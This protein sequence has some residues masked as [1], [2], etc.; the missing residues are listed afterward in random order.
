MYGVYPFGSAPFGAAPA[1][2]APTAPTAERAL[3]LSSR[4]FNNATIVGSTE[5]ASLPASYLQDVQPAKVWRLTSKIGQYLA[6]TLAR[7][8]ACDTV[9]F[10]AANFTSA[11]VC[12]VIAAN[13]S[14]SLPASPDFNSG[15]K[16]VWP[17]T[18]KSLDDDIASFVCLVRFANTDAYQH[19]RIEIADPGAETSYIEIGRVMIG[20]AFQLPI[21]LNLGIGLASPDA[22]ARTPYGR[23]YGDPRGNA[24]RRFVLPI[25]ALNDVLMKRSLL[26]LQRYCG[27]AR[28]FVFSLDPGATTDLHLYTMQ[29]QF[30]DSAQFESAM[31]W[32]ADGQMWITTLTLTE[33]L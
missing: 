17:A 8:V 1:Y 24:S 23:T 14:A 15:W 16:S 32:D 25:T 3:F 6:I 21:D 2:V 28:D 31:K 33:P 10:I 7:P 22:Q 29:A 30:T 26:A 5:V 13:S 20:L 19:W 18:G 4:E 9:A 27:L 12:R 11:A